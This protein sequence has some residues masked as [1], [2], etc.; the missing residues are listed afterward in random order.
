MIRVWAHEC[1]RVFHDRLI[2]QN[3]Q[4][5][6]LTQL[7]SIVK[8]NFNKDWSSISESDVIIWA[9]F[10]PTIYPNDDTSKKP[11]N[12]IYCEIVLL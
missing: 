4:N 12:D 6:F 10:V 8:Q 2:D 5:F 11:L 9:S 7:K 1:M 3:D